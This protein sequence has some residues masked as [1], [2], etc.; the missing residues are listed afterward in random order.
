[1]YYDC[2]KNQFISLINLFFEINKF[3]IIQIIFNYLKSSLK[4]NI[5]KL[6]KNINI[7]LIIFYTFFKL[8]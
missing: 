4:L 6:I 3:F 8:N 1:M 2:L 7:L 5:I